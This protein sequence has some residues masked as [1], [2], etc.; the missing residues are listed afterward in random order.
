MTNIKGYELKKAIIDFEVEHAGFQR[1]ER[2]V[3]GEELEILWVKTTDDKAFVI[4]R[5]F[6]NVK[7]TLQ[8]A[9]IPN[10]QQIEEINEDEANGVAYIAYKTIQS[11]KPELNKHN[12]AQVVKTL[13]ALKLKNQQGLLLN[14][15]TI[16]QDSGGE[17]KLRFVGL[18]ELFRKG[19]LPMAGVKPHKRKMHDDIIAASTF[20]ESFLTNTEKG[21][22]IFNKCQSGQYD[23]Y[24]EL[25][26]DIK[27][28]PNEPNPDWD[29]I[30]ICANA[31]KIDVVVDDLVNDLNSGCWLKTDSKLSDRGDVRG[32]WST[33]Q[34]SGKFY[35]NIK[36]HDDSSSYGHLFILDPKLYPDENCLREGEKLKLN[37]EN[38][39][40][41]NKYYKIP[42]NL[43]PDLINELA[44]LNENKKDLIQKWKALP[45]AEKKHI[46]NSAFRA[47]YKSR[48]HTK[49][50]KENIV[51]HLENTFADWEQ[52]KNKKK[53]GIILSIN[54]TYMGKIGDHH[55][56]HKTIVIKDCKEPLGAIPKKGE[57]IEDVQKLTSQYKKQIEA[58][59]KFNTRDIINPELSAI[60]ANPEQTKEQ[61]HL[62][63]D[64]DD[65]ESKIINPKL[66]E[67][68]TQ[69]NAV[70]QA[71]HRKP[72]Y[73]I[74]G[75]PGTGKTTVIVELIEQFINDNK[76]AKILVVSQSNPAVDNVLERVLEKKINFIR[77]A[78]EFA[79]EKDN[80]SP[81]IEEHTFDTKLKG[82]ANKTRGRSQSNFDELSPK[83]DLVLYKLHKDFSKQK[84]KSHKSFTSLYRKQG[85]LI[86][87][88]EKIFGNAK[89][90]EEI[91]AI[92][93]DKLGARYM[94][95]KK[96][97]SDWLAY[98][99]NAT[100]KKQGDSICTMKHGSKDIPLEVAY[101][102]SMN[103]FGSTCIH[104][105]SGKYSDIDFRFDVMIMDESSKATDAESLVPI[106][107]S[108][109]IILIGDHKQLP[110]IVTRDKEVHDAIIEEIEDEGLDIEKTYGKSMFERLIDNFDSNTRLANLF[111]MLEIQ[112]RMPRQIGYLI[113]EFIYDG[114]LKNPS[115]KKAPSYDEDKYHNIPLKNKH[116]NICG[117]Q[118]LNSIVMVTT[119]HLDNRFD[120]GDK[121]SRANDANIKII[122]DVLQK[123]SEISTQNHKI[124]T[125]VGVIAAYRGQ[126]EKLKVEIN[127]KNY[128]QLQIDI[129]TVDKFQGSEKDIMIYDIVRGSAGKSS[130]GFLDDYR[131]INV[132]F[133]R[134]KKLLIIVGDS[135]YII[136]RVQINPGSHIEDRE[137][138]HLVKIIKRLAEWGCIYPILEDALDY[139]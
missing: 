27:G 80:I 5:V 83:T 26:D 125:E 1:A 8:E 16:L 12:L 19:I 64:Y 55:P 35:V 85:S 77:L 4:S 14:E 72:V 109:K 52:V 13:K 66:K 37:F 15:H 56:Q 120:N 126:V 74:Q 60:I 58:C 106:K 63:I 67:D 18:D 110:P 105:A 21:S 61:I 97:H 42:E 129:N 132:A 119:S 139:E 65:F 38:G 33:E 73:L 111:S 6:K 114:K 87:Y 3:D 135:E 124:P 107:M 101:A 131:R 84:V 7:A 25:L 130:I 31:E 23:K 69:K 127:P 54:D 91:E 28:L 36:D 89:S 70:I 117:Q 79:V 71:L 103:V 92:F 133:S 43:T 102:K 113:S 48:K 62:E 24:P 115:L 29:Y 82:W 128:P 68:E 41:E 78:S 9:K 116:V 11:K 134:A 47:T 138:L 53:N 57:L 118:M 112:Y 39:M 76:S 123:L 2:E 95:L 96:I 10:L 40:Y 22:E 34:T 44:R 81:K 99:N 94:K 100:S 45:E 17:I 46:E 75:P 20:F 108:K 104:I 98:I 88:Y 59:D 122:K 90:I 30:H 137:D 50:N 32:T 121:L 51:F 93:S 49:N 86:N 136:E